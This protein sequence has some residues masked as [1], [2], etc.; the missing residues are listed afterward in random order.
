MMSK[1]VTMAMAFPVGMHML[2]LMHM[3]RAHLATAA[4][5]QNTRHMLKLDGGV[6]D[7][8]AAAHVINPP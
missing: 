6:M 2:V 3:I 8:Q 4:T 5:R 7:A 1:T